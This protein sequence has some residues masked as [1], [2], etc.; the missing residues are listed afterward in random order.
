MDGHTYHFDQTNQRQRSEEHSTPDTLSIAASSTCAGSSASGIG[1]KAKSEDISAAK[2][3]DHVEQSNLLRR[4]HQHTQ[5]SHQHNHHQPRRE[6][7]SLGLAGLTTDRDSDS[8][9]SCESCNLTGYTKD[10]TSLPHSTDSSYT[11][12]KN[13]YSMAPLHDDE[14]NENVSFLPS[15]ND[16]SRASR[17][18]RRTKGLM[19]K[20]FRQRNKLVSLG[21]FIFIAIQVWAWGPDL[22]GKERVEEWRAHLDC[23]CQHSDQY[24]RSELIIRDLTAWR[25]LGP[26]T[27]HFGGQHDTQYH[28]PSPHHPQQSPPHP[29]PHT[30]SPPPT[31]THPLDAIASPLPVGY[32]EPTSDEDI[33]LSLSSHSFPA[34]IASYSLHTAKPEH[35]YTEGN[36]HLGIIP[37]SFLK[38]LDR[39]I[40]SQPP[41]RPGAILDYPTDQYI[42]HSG[43]SAAINGSRTTYVDS[44]RPEK[45]ALE[46]DWRGPPHNAW[47][48]PLAEM[49]KKKK[50]KIP[51]IQFTFSDPSKHSGSKSS[52]D[53]DEL[54]KYRQK[55][56][57]NAFVHSWEGYKKKA[58]GHDEIKP[59]SEMAQDNFNGWG[60][61]IVDALDTLLIMDLP[62]EYDYARQHVRDIDFHLVGGGRSAY[63]SADGQIPVFETAIRYL[64]GFISAYDL[65]G[66]ELMRDRAEELAQLILP[67]FDTPT[68]VPIGRIRF[69]T[70][71][72]G[73]GAGG[74]VL[75]AE[76]ASL[77]LEMTRLWQVTGN[78]TY[79]DRVQRTTDWLD[80]NMTSTTNRLGTLWATTLFPERGTMYGW[81]TW[82]GMADSAFEY[83]IKEHQLLGGQL[84]QYGRMFS[85]V[86]DSAMQWLLRPINTVP[87]APLLVLGQSNGNT[88][89]P[90]LEHLT[91]FAGGSMAM[92]GK[93]LPGR[94]DDMDFARRFTE[95]CYWAY[96]STATGIGPELQTF[97]KD[98]DLD[99]FTS[100]SSKDGTTRRGTPNGA[101]IVGVRDV[102]PDY[103][104]RPE[105]IESIFYLWRTTGDPIWQERGWQMFC[106]WVT[107]SMTKVGF[108]SLSS[109][110]QVPAFKTDS[111]ESYVFAETFK[112]Y[113]LLFSPPDFISLDDFVFTTEA[114]PV[115]VP[116]KGKYAPPGSG[117]HKLW[118]LK[119]SHVPSDPS[120]YSGGEMKEVGG[121]TAVQRQIVY[122]NW[123][124]EAHRKQS[125]KLLSPTLK[126]E[127][128]NGILSGAHHALMKRMLNQSTE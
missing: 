15:H 60:A 61:T 122:L 23:E 123:K 92:S 50:V 34:Q 107:H 41:P 116:Q 96:N 86:L 76:A 101:P 65:A 104:N 81:Y 113:Y 70:P 6:A 67:A 11:M 12:S 49:S 117:P 98:K 119:A 27:P 88:Y 62:K 63:G 75:L 89:T 77:L 9:S 111:M 103:R 54:I 13:I 127:G 91:C 128:K 120:V 14:E 115:L 99:R 36:P 33:R 108:S 72:R 97:Y 93:L 126:D 37:A 35:L 80:K 106:S 8:N 2:E 66:D 109:V 53:R 45:Q 22:V 47:Q 44:L 25:P 94:K 3:R 110:L 40:I 38:M 55:L 114:H 121:L 10:T 82:G 5:R 83:L 118:D 26:S 42:P 1:S 125:E 28:P 71:V 95:T 52:T 56:V 48:P 79:F 73:T 17:A 18:S 85:D 43:W 59:V 29:G 30:P 20:A 32:E 68:G 4:R 84:E 124:I 39:E 19:S 46:E 24:H 58:W 51:K 21:V 64:G 100:L 105:T 74:G 57:R 78:R 112:Y 102:L 16:S 69:E 31:T 7:Q 90:R 87:G